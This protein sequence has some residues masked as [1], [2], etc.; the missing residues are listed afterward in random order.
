M[1]DC[2][3][4]VG[5]FVLGDCDV[6]KPGVTVDRLGRG[7]V[8]NSDEELPGRLVS[9]EKA[10]APDCLDGR[11]EEPGRTAGAGPPATSELELGACSVWGL[12]CETATSTSTA[13]EVAGR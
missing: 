11:E 4:L 12:S 8:G 5:D 10:P 3:E 2:L 7:D 9:L 13:A 6:A 1:E